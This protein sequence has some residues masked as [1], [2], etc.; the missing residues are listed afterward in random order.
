MPPLDPRTQLSV[1]LGAILGKHR[2]DADPQ[3]AIDELRSAAGPDV[4]LLA[5]ATGTWAGFYGG[6]DATAT[7]ARALIERIEGA[8]EWVAL[9]EQRRGGTH[10]T[11][12][13]VRPRLHELL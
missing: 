5:E 12:G 7:L 13:Y 3:A 1:R 11:G 8:A 4:E 10:G 6:A 9:G 2:F